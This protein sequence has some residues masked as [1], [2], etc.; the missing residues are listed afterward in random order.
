MPAL[1]LAQSI[2]GI[3]VLSGS[4]NRHAYAR[5]QDFFNGAFVV[6]L[7]GIS[8]VQKSAK[9]IATGSSRNCRNEVVGEA[10]I[11][12]AEQSVACAVLPD[13]LSRLFA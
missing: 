5:M 11:N 6:Q 1:P 2:F 3:V 12:A 9:S 7:A 4:C 8:L 13:R 10:K